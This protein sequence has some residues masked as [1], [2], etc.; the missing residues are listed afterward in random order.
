MR[1]VPINVGI[2]MLKP[3]Q[4]QNNRV[5]DCDNSE[6]LSFWM[7]TIEMLAK[8]SW[9]IRP[10]AIG[11]SSTTIIGTGVTTSKILS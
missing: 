5:T 11:R 7:G 1:L 9:V 6:S 10:D 2:V 8:T 3:V 4:S